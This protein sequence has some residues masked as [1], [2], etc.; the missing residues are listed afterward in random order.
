MK[1]WKNVLWFSLANAIIFYLAYM[2]FGKDVVFGNAYSGTVQSVIVSA[3]L[4]GLAVS[5]VG[6]WGQTK[7]YSENIWMLVYWAVNILV[8]LLIAR[9][10]ISKFTGMGIKQSWIALVLG[11]VINCAQ[12]GVWK[13]MAGKK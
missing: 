7:K 6:L 2:F 8:I 10:P 4:V 9:S 5:A 13:A 3:V 11:F 12:Y 1:F